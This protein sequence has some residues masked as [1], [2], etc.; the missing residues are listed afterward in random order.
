MVESP[1]ILI[2]NIKRRKRVPRS[3]HFWNYTSR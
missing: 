3:L 2:L 1:S